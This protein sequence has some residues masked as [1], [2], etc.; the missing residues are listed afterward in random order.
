MPNSIKILNGRVDC[1]T[2][3]EIFSTIEKNIREN[4]F[5]QIITV[6]TLMLLETETDK[7]LSEIF[8]S[9]AMAVLESSGISLVS[10]LKRFPKIKRIPGIDLMIELC[11]K[12]EEKEW[13][14]YLLGAKPDAVK[15]ASL[16]LQ[17]QFPRLKIAGIHHGYFNQKEEK[18]ILEEIRRKNAKIIFVGMSMPFQEKWIYKNLI[19]FNG[20]CAMGVGGSF[21]VISGNL[22]RAPKWMRKTGLEWLFRFILEPWRLKRILHLPLFLLKVLIRK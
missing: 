4:L 14:V 20:V 5:L 10:A 16:N 21:D 11:R 2:L 22:T 6:N 3:S 8:N 15:Q 1:V 13:A 12:S 9:N 18:K 17:K 7:E 19:N